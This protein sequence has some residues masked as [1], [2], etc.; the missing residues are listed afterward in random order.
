MNPNIFKSTKL[1]IG[2]GLAVMTG[3]LGVSCVEMDLESHS[4]LSS[5]TI[6]TDPVSA[7]G[8]IVSCYSSFKSLYNDPANLWPET[9]GSQMDRDPNWFSIGMLK[10]T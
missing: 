5:K 3:A 7:E 1:L 9:M 4:Q 10:G 8:A 6:W 2:A